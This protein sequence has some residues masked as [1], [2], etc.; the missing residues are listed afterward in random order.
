MK[1]SGVILLTMMII[2]SVAGCSFTGN[3]RDILFQVQTIGSLQEGVFEG[4]VT[5]GELK[6]YGDFGGWGT[7]EG[8]DGEM[9]ILDGVVYQIKGDGKV[10]LPSNTERT[11]FASITY[12]DADKKVPINREVNS[13]QLQELLD[14]Q[15]PTKNV[16]FAIRIDGKFDYIK[17]RAPDKQAKPYPTLAKALEKQNV[18]EFKDIEGTILALRSPSYIGSVN[19][20]G[21][22]IHFISKDRKSGGHLLDCLIKNVDASYDET[23]GF[24]MIL[25]ETG[26]FSQTD[27]STDKQSE[28][29]KI[30]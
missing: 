11:P 5:V 27:L 7:F 17:A 8:L 6:K 3:D 1:I 13:A 12:F 30:E 18:F 2:V 19:V 20:P 14:S 21:Y 28:L 4:N 16:F 24:M 9:I 25:S 26:A 29:K 22:H 15:L 23:A 10:Y